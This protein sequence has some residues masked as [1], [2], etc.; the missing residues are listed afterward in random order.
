MNIWNNLIILL[1]SPVNGWKL[2]GKYNIPKEYLFSK[3]FGPL[4]GLLAISV[5]VIFFYEPQLGLTSL[6][7]RAISQVGQTY[8]GYIISV[9]LLISVSSKNNSEPSHEFTTRIHIFCMYCYSLLMIFSIIIN[10]IPPDLIEI[11]RIMP[12]YVAFVIWKAKDYIN[13]EFSESKFVIIYALSVL[14]PYYILSYIFNS[15]INF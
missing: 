4:L 5:F 6:L 3:L 9:F 15:L 13:T 8:F 2:V 11:F 7:Q 10:I 12:L 1:T 14:L